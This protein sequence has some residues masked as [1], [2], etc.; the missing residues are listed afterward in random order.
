MFSLRHFFVS[1]KLQNWVVPWIVNHPVHLYV[2]DGFLRNHEI[3]E[4]QISVNTTDLRTLGILLF[5]TQEFLEV[6]QF[7]WVELLCC[8]ILYY[9][10][11][12]SHIN[13]FNWL[14]CSRDL[15]QIMRLNKLQ[16][17][18]FKTYLL[19]AVYRD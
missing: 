4:I 1:P 5:V 13:L 16:Q 6:K 11:L 18:L 8:F 17:R 19:Q 9:L 10:I 3:Y 7:S 14:D 12:R 15:F 2:W